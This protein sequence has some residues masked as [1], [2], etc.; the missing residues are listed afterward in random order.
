MHSPA[1]LS[2][3]GDTRRRA[4]HDPAED[5]ERA[6]YR[7]SN[8]EIYVPAMAVL[9]AM[10]E[11]GKVHKAK[12]QGRKSVSSFVLSG[13][14]VQ[15]DEIILHPQQYEIDSRPVSVQRARIIRHRPIFREWSI[16][17]NIRIVNPAMFDETLVRNLLEDAGKFYGLLDFRPYYGLFRITEMTNKAT[18]KPVR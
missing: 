8:G 7:N 5:A 6:C 9:A 1:D 16:S 12:G 17:F 14:R 13:I 11:A 10:R 18:G 3:G 2:D 15:P 4:H